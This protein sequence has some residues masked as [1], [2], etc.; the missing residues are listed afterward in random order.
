LLIGLGVACFRRWSRAK[1]AREPQ[2][3]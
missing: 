2:H 3:D 1:E